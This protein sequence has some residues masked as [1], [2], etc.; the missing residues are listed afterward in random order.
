MI[1]I[2]GLGA[3]CPAMV[4]KGSVIESIVLLS[5]MT[6]PTSNTTMRGPL[7]SNASRR[8]PAPDASKF[9]TRMI[10]PPKPPLVGGPKATL[11][12]M[13]VC[14]IVSWPDMHPNIKRQINKWCI[15]ICSFMLS[16]FKF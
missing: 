10:W 6:P 8:E 3:V 11:P 2:P 7:V 16:E 15:F 1:V 5:L 12:G 9:V 13:V 14:A 4:R